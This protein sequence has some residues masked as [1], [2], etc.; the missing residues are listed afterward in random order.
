MG[1]NRYNIPFNSYED[2]AAFLHQTQLMLVVRLM[3]FFMCLYLMIAMFCLDY[4]ECVVTGVLCASSSSAFILADATANLQW[5]ESNLL[6]YGHK[7]SLPATLVNMALFPFLVLCWLPL[8]KTLEEDRKMLWFH[9]HGPSHK[10]LVD[11]TMSLS[12]QHAA[13][14]CLRRWRSEFLFQDTSCG[15]HSGVGVGTG[16]GMTRTVPNEWDP[17]NSGVIESMLSEPLDYNFVTELLDQASESPEPSSSNDSHSSQVGNEGPLMAHDNSSSAGRN[18]QR[19]QKRSRSPAA[20]RYSGTQ[21]ECFK[22]ARASSEIM[23][24]PV[25]LCTESTPQ[26]F[27]ALASASGTLTTQEDPRFDALLARMGNGDGNQGRLLLRMFLISMNPFME[28][29]RPLT[30]ESAFGNTHVQM[31]LVSLLG[32]TLCHIHENNKPIIKNEPAP[33]P[34]FLQRQ[35]P[36]VPS[37]HA[38]DLSQDL[39]DMLATKESPANATTSPAIVTAIIEGAS[40]ALSISPAAKPYEWKPF[41]PK[42]PE[43][44]EVPHDLIWCPGDYIANQSVA[45]VAP[46]PGIL[47]LQAHNEIVWCDPDTNVQTQKRYNRGSSGSRPG[48]EHGGSGHGMTINILDETPWLGT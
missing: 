17:W 26:D 10:A 44:D 43:D 24:M 14:V 2:G 33:G 9:Q 20:E 34:E 32:S 30:H 19:E 15:T 13:K 6:N 22:Q 45:Q 21:K 25:D 35:K 7:S 46:S 4:F 47:G 11:V 39:Q 37:S 3:L 42:N 38:Q 5:D 16:G 36:S 23:Q 28:S 40:L 29:S 18:P 41:D 27:W 31:T 12:T 48:Q 8:A 1:E